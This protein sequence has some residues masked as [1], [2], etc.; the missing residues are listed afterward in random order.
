VWDIQE[1]DINNC[2]TY[3]N[4][5]SSRAQSLMVVVAA[6]AAAVAVAVVVVVVTK[7]IVFQLLLGTQVTEYKSE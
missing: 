6:A 5:N 3:C 2:P 1:E 4:W 7:F